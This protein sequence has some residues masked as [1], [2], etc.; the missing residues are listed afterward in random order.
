M[1]LDELLAADTAKD[2]RLNLRVL[3]E[4]K[5]LSP[6]QAWG[7]ALAAAYAARGASVLR[8]VDAEAQAHLSPEARRAATVAAT[9]M[10][11]NNIYYRFTHLVGAP[12]YAQLPA[13]LRMQ[14]MANPGVP[15]VDFELYSLAASAVNGCGACLVAHEQQLRAG[16]ATPEMVQEAARIAAVV[17]AAAVAV[18]GAE[19]LQAASESSM[20][21]RAR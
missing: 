21:T 19:A 3:R 12:E 5:Q 15:R 6:A 10:G 8:A 14:G 7:A 1:T 13:G 4:A 20:G 16:G 17:H 9:L 11:M 18:E 2:L